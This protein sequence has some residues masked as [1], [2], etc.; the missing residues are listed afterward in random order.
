M[1]RRTFAPRAYRAAFAG[2][3]GLAL[4]GPTAWAADK[5]LTIGVNDALT[6]PGAVYGQPQANAISMAA[7]EI[8]DAGGIKV[9]ADT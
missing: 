5:E 9:G 3:L 4:A 6:G 1:N 2:L 8:N 7:K